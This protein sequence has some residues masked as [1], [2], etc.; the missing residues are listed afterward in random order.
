MGPSHLHAHQVCGAWPTL[1]W[2]SL[3]LLEPSLS[4]QARTCIKGE[5]WA[6]SPVSWCLHVGPGLYFH[7]T[8][9][10][11]CWVLTFTCPLAPLL[12]SPEPVLPGSWPGDSLVTRVCTERRHKTWGLDPGVPW[13]LHT[14]SLQFLSSES[15]LTVLLRKLRMRNL[16]EAELSFSVL[17]LFKLPFEARSHALLPVAAHLLY[18]LRLGEAV[19]SRCPMRNTLMPPR[20]TCFP[21]SF[22]TVNWCLTQ[23]PAQTS[24][25]WPRMTG[26]SQ[27]LVL[28]APQKSD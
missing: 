20:E 22:K 14:A 3:A 8:L 4:S 10:D 5:K 17:Y 1:S 12:L 13:S 25:G 6:H 23:R 27:Y 9:E 21:S 28:L 11:C 7:Q 19:N 18:L 2:V 16:G 24:S 26:Y 15:L